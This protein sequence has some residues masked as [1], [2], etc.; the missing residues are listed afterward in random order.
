MKTHNSMFPGVLLGIFRT[1]ATS[2]I[3]PPMADW[4]LLPHRI[5]AESLW[6]L[7]ISLF[8]SCVAHTYSWTSFLQ[9]SKLKS[10]IIFFSYKSRYVVWMLPPLPLALLT[11]HF[12]NKAHFYFIYLLFIYFCPV[13]IRSSC[14]ILYTGYSVHFFSSSFWRREWK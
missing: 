10:E 4:L 6:P 9:S 11:Y 13:A 5:V 12:T 2:I 7:L 8:F 3:C 14:R 1:A